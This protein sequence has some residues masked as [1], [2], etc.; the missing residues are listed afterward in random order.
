MHTHAG[1]QQT[2][3]FYRF[4]DITHQ[5]LQSEHPYARLSR[6]Q[7]QVFFGEL[8]GVLSNIVEDDIVVDYFASMLDN[9]KQPSEIINGL[10][11]IIGDVPAS[12]VVNW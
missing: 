4:V 5:I 6:G 9:F 8:Q 2:I 12:Y 11:D 1:T 7:K 10:S 3:Q